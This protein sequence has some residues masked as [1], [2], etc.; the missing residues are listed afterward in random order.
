[1][2]TILLN[3]KTI[4]TGLLIA[5]GFGYLADIVGTLSTVEGG[6]FSG[7][8]NTVGNLRGFSLYVGAHIAVVTIGLGIVWPTVARFDLRANPDAVH[9]DPGTQASLRDSFSLAWA[10]IGSGKRLDIFVRVFLGEL[11]AA[12]LCFHG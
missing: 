5:V 2:K 12:A 1:M 10:K 4:L 7:L 11:I 8:A 6:G 3:W 9:N